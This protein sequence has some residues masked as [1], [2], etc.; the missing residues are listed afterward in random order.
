MKCLSLYFYYYW[1]KVKAATSIADH[2]FEVTTCEIS[3]GYIIL[4]GKYFWLSYATVQEMY[5][6]LFQKLVSLGVVNY[7]GWTFS[8]N[9]GNA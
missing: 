6:L 9:P 8:F 1:I 5:L 3:L 2:L 7:S 4:P